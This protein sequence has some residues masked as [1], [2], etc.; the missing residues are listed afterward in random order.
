MASPAARAHAVVCD[1]RSGSPS[2][3]RPAMRSRTTRS[4][5]PCHARMLDRRIRQVTRTRGQRH[6]P[7]QRH[8]RGCGLRTHRSGGAQPLQSHH[9]QVRPRRRL[10]DSPHGAR[11]H[12]QVGS[13]WWS[14][15]ALSHGRSRTRC[16]GSSRRSTAVRCGGRIRT[17]LHACICT[18]CA[19]RGSAP[20]APAGEP[21]HARTELGATTAAAE[22]SRGSTGRPGT[23]AV[24]TP[25]ATRG[26]VSPGTAHDL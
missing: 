5:A 11:R 12:R 25:P 22:A 26:A 23:G 10:D 6:R 4:R 13:S 21:D 16:V 7:R 15:L 8:N 3:A 9:R 17:K 24:H 1:R 18:G 2:S 20:G 14:I 19:P